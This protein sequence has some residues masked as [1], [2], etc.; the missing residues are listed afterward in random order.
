MDDERATLN[1]ELFVLG[2]SFSGELTIA[3]IRG[4]GPD[5]EY[6]RSARW[7]HKEDLQTLIVYPEILK[8]SFWDD[9]GRGFPQAVY[10]GRT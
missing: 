5:E 9:L 6:I 4:K 3:N 7:L 8:G 1:L 10:L 2:R